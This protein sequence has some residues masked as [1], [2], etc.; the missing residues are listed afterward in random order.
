MFRDIDACGEILGDRISECHFTFSN[1]VSKQ[2]SGKHFADGT[3]LEEG[4]AA[5][6]TRVCLAEMAILDNSFTLR[7]D[8]A[9]NDA[10]AILVAGENIDPV[11]EYLANLS[12]GRENRLTR[13]LP[14]LSCGEGRGQ[15]EE[16]RNGKYCASRHRYLGFNAYV[17]DAADQVVGSGLAF[18]HRND[19]DGKILIVGTQNQMIA[20]S[21]HIFHCAIVVLENGV[22]IELALAIRFE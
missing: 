21:F 3:N 11:G 8:Y 12:V 9:D 7:P 22:H 14:C 16:N 13:D 6:R 15:A 20:G 19:F 5:E 10:D 4:V 17:A 2:E 18:F 1:H